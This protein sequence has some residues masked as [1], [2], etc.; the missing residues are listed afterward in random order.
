MYCISKNAANVQT[1]NY[2]ATTSG[3]FITTGIHYRGAGL[4]KYDEKRSVFN[5]V[6]KIIEIAKKNYGT[7]ITKAN[8]YDEA[9]QDL[10]QDCVEDLIVDEEA[11]ELAF[12]GTRFFDLM[13]MAH[14]HSNPAYLAERVSL[15]NGQKDV[16]LYGKLLDSKNW[17]FPLPQK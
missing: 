13:R 5:Y 14:R 1:F 7:T 10:V 6:D 15:R 9:Y 16:A 17:Y 4:L 11:M 3:T 8:I 2:S 12:E